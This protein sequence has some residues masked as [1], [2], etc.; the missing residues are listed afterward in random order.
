MNKKKC[1]K[2]GH[3]AE[4]I[5]VDDKGYKFYCPKCYKISHYDDYEKKNKPV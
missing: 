5:G 3:D 4:M 2:C 1:K